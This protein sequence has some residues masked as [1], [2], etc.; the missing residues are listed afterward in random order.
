MQDSGLGEPE[1]EEEVPHELFCSICFLPARDPQQTRCACA[2]LYCLECV[3]KY[4]QV[5]KNCPTCRRPLDV[6]PDGLSARRIKSLR[7][8][9]ANLGSGCLWVNELGNLGS[10]LTTCEYATIPCANGCGEAVIRKTASVHHCPLQRFSCP[11]C[12][13]EGTL[14][15]M[16]NS[17]LE[18]C[19]DL[20]VTCPNGCGVEQLVRK[21]IESHRFQCP[22]EII[23][24]PYAVVG[25]TSTFHRVELEGHKVNTV[26]QHLDLA[27]LYVTSTS[28]SQGQAISA[29]E[30]SFRS[31]LQTRDT[32][33]A[34]LNSKVSTLETLTAPVIFRMSDYAKHKS[35]KDPWFS[36]G[37]Y[38]H[39][40]GYRACLR[41]Y[42]NGLGDAEGTHLSVFV[43]LMRGQNDQSLIWPLRADFTITLLNQLRDSDHKEC[44]AAMHS[45]SDE[46]FNMRVMGTDVGSSARG[47]AKF[48]SHHGLLQ[49]KYHQYLKGGTLHF[50]V[51][52]DILPACKPWLFAAN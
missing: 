22:K 9:C 23:K 4:G 2:K 16:T 8:R 21:N 6:F 3:V 39:P 48:I 33:I 44:V 45:D 36:P 32:T 25:C 35:S 13:E 41:V 26:Q 31:L 50:K 11:H 15:E 1:F 40:G 38:T 49:D 43:N 12:K 30:N 37:F 24:C 34:Q 29:L 19:P 51:V 28:V 52:V 14:R 46:K 10:H 42:A 47:H 5:S 18:R 20:V 7:V 27:M 17:H